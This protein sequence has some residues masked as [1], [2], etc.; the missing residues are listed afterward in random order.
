MSL[1]LLNRKDAVLVNRE[2]GIRLKLGRLLPEHI[3]EM[4]GIL[5]T[6]RN[7]SIT[8]GIYVLREA[9]SELIVNGEDYD[10]VRLS[11]TADTKDPDVAAVM[12]GVSALAIQDALVDEAMRKKSPSPQPPISEPSDAADAR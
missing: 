6:S 11:Y 5:R 7:A 3:A 4:Q 8:L 2:L 9:A 1:K 12:T 10:P